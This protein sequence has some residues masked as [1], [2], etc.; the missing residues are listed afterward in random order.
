MKNDV[1][2]NAST[3]RIEQGPLTA[4]GFT[5]SHGN[6][7]IICGGYPSNPA[8]SPEQ[9]RLWRIKILLKF[10]F[11]AVLQ[12]DGYSDFRVEIRFSCCIAAFGNNHA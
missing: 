11:L 6:I 1:L 4:S 9:G 12:I 2:T 10:Q 3:A 7:L 5:K 8:F